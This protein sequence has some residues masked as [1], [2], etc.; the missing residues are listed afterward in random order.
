MSSSKRF[1]ILKFLLFIYFFISA[2]N[3]ESV[4][5][6]SPSCPGTCCVDLVVLECPEIQLPLPFRYC[7]SACPAL[8]KR[9]VLIFVCVC[10]SQTNACVCEGSC[11]VHKR[12]SAFLELELQAD[13]GG[14]RGVLGTEQ[15]P[16]QEQQ[17]P[18]HSEL[19][20]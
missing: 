1:S 8:R 11:G 10:V 9:L 13:V 2:I 7:V 6:R 14:L 5:P 18:L 12:V 20:L 16:L 15:G 3:R 19:S 17:E 4:S